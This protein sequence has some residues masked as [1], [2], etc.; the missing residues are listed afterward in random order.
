M[1]KTNVKKLVRMAILSAMGIVLMIW[2]RL[3]IIP[4]APWL[5][6]E[7]ADVPI[8]IGA[9]MYGP[10]AGFVITLVVSAIQAFTVSAASGWVGFVMHV[11]ATGTLVLVAGTI[12]KFIHSRKGAIIALI[13]GALSMTAIMV[14]TNLFFTV[15]FWGAPYDAVVASIVPV[16]LPF[17]LIKAGLNSIIVGLLYKPLSRFLKDHIVRG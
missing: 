11:I 6:Y 17:N 13:A 5:E 8:L 9:F 3:P 7:M 4:A 10:A 16:I 14:P 15:R 2:P 1:R 12:Y